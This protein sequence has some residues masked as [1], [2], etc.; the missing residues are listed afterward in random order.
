MIGNNKR[1][2][3]YSALAGYILAIGTPLSGQ[4]IYVD[5][6]PDIALDVEFDEGTDNEYFDVNGDGV[7]DFEVELAYSSG[8]FSCS[9]YISADIRGLFSNRI[10]TGQIPVYSY[11]SGDSFYMEVA[12]L[13]GLGDIIDLNGTFGAGDQTIFWDDLGDCGLGMVGDDAFI[14]KFIGF[15]LMI[16]GEA[17][18]GWM[19]LSLAGNYHLRIHDYAYSVE[20]D[21]GI[22]TEYFYTPG[23]DWEEVTDVGDEISGADIYFRF[24]YSNDETPISEY[25]VICV[26]ESM[27]ATFTLAEALALPADQYLSVMPVG[28]MFYDGHLDGEV[29]DTDGDLITNH[30]PYKLFV[31]SL[32]DLGNVLS[33]ASPSIY[34][35][36]YL[37]PPDNLTINDIG[38]TFSASDIKVKIYPSETENLIQEY[39][40]IFLKSPSIDFTLS[41]AL[42]VPAENYSTF[43][44][45]GSNIECIPTADQRD[46]NGEIIE[47]CTEY[48]AAVVSMPNAFGNA[49]LLDFTPYL[50]LDEATTLASSL[51]LSDIGNN[52]NSTDLQLQFEIADHPETVNAYH[53]MIVPD[54]MIDS[55]DKEMAQSMT[56]DKYVIFNTDTSGVFSTNFPAGFRDIN[57]I[58]IAEDQLYYAFILSIS[59]ELG[60]QNELS[61]PSNGVLLYTPTSL[62]ENIPAQMNIFY[63]N[64]I[65]NISGNE[66]LGKIVVF[67]NVG[68]QLHSTILSE[69]NAYINIELSPGI[70]IL[71]KWHENNSIVVK[72]IVTE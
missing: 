41:D 47:T 6:D 35:D 58:P 40:V 48:R 3:Q 7:N 59:S 21:S 57:D 26:K 5:V 50:T 51:L 31:L 17:H 54:Y 8:C 20:P 36:S 67:N 14:S 61:S 37:E 71:T 42:L 53:I 60:K 15:K 18:Y 39:R 22:T 69:A 38:D 28:S 1:L 34:L 12:E 23:I 32:N 52:A 19:R 30:V 4:V 10:E 13:H 46:A 2:K 16:D 43:V 66:S 33:E 27:A 11:C 65:L 9:W 29:Y 56:P 62:E 24:Y 64:G 25:R 70:Y 63:A 45:T 44:P 72:F 49:P 55:F 68:Q